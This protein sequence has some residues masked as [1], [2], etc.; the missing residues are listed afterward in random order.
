[1][2]ADDEGCCRR[3]R[4]GPNVVRGD[5]RLLSPEAQPQ[6]IKALRKAGV[7]PPRPGGERKAQPLAG[8]TFVSPYAA[9]HV[10]RRGQGELIELGRQV[11]GSVSKTPLRGGG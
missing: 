8:K 5:S 9:G 3:S 4:I 6:V 11:A 2:D 10:A 7:E 1:M